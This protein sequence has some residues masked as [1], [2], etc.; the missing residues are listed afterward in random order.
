MKRLISE[1]LFQFFLLGLG[2]FIANHVWESRVARADYTIHVS[3]AEIERQAAIFATENRRQP[4]DED[5]KALLFAHV[6]EQVLMREAERLGLAEDDT[7]IRRRLAQKMR[8]MIE[9]GAPLAPPADAELEAWFQDR[10]AQFTPPEKRSF[11]HVYLSPETQ[12]ENIEAN[13]KALLSQITDD[14]WE[15][16]GDPFILNRNYVGLSPAEIRRD[17]GSSFAAD[18][19]AIEPGGWAGPISSAYGLHLVRIDNRQASVKPEFSDVKDEVLKAWQEQT[20][21]Q[22]N[23]DRLTELLE[24]YTV[25]VEDLNP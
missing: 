16:L 7:I 9:D 15:N 24:Q 21:R 1:P 22:A 4:T 20:R 5:I 17:F 3:A 10:I 18:L 19:F 8:F 25:E 23:Q 13:A 11:S 14:N 12:G 2:L 6:E